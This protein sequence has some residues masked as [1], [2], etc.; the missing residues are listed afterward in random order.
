M[1]CQLFHQS[2][3]KELAALLTATYGTQTHSLSSI[4]SDDLTMGEVND[5]K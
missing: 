3:L 1:S 2:T 4:I 5:F